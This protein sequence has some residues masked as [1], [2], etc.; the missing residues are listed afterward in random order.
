MVLQ[1]CQDEEGRLKWRGIGFAEPH[2]RLKS[3][4]KNQLQ[5][6]AEVGYAKLNDS[7]DDISDFCTI[8]SVCSWL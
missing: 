2:V 1:I 3:R 6:I 8:L 5:E 4:R 7:D